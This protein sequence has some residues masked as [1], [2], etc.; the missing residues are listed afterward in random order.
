MSTTD[1]LGLVLKAADVSGWDDA[2]NDAF[3]SISNLTAKRSR[4]AT[5]S[6]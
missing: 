2:L 1:Y 3:D 4:S 5:C 6:C